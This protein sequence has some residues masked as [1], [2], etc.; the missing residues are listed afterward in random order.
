MKVIT[1]KYLIYF[2]QTSQ[3]D[4]K[5]IKSCAKNNITIF[6]NT[7]TSTH[8][9]CEQIILGC[10]KYRKNKYCCRLSDEHLNAVRMQLRIYQHNI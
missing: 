8:I 3:I 4:F 2:S 6:C 7:Y 1:Y 5:G 10:Y 9:L